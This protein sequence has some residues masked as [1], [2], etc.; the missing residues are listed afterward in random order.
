MNLICCVPDLHLVRWAVYRWINSGPEVQGR[1]PSHSPLLTGQEVEPLPQGPGSVREQ[2]PD[3]FLHWKKRR[4]GRSC[5]E[6]T[7]TCVRRRFPCAG[8]G[9]ASD[10][11]LS[12][13]GLSAPCQ[14][15]CFRSELEKKEEMPILGGGRF[16]DI[17]EM[18]GKDLW[19]T[20]SLNR[21]RPL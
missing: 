12:L 3:S 2:H 1:A 8:S 6:K 14:F 4:G 17:A 16:G 21:P 10:P 11:W 18:R 13:F 7:L 9:A 5:S 19:S 15:Y 20:H